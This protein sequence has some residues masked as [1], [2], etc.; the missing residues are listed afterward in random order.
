MI[1]LINYRSTIEEINTTTTSILNTLAACDFSEDQ[2]LVQTIKDIS[3]LNQK[4]TETLKEEIVRSTLAPL[5]AVRDQSAR[6]IF[7]E[8]KAKLLWP[9][10]EIVAAA[11]AVQKILDNYGMEML[12]LSYSAESSNINALLDDLKKQNLVPALKKLHGFDTLIVQLEKD[13]KVFEFAFQEYIA[14][15]AEQSKMLSAGK[16]GEMVKNQINK[17]LSKY[18][19]VMSNV[20]PGIYADCYS[21]I[22]TIIKDNNAK[23]KAR[24]SKLKEKEEV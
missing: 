10:K 18:L 13:Q 21:K 5:D 16:L 24:L 9:D 14:R 7:L 12:N 3:S 2:Y 11:K 23:V 22:E 17:E 4:M 20:K 6:V 19:D 8:I 1:T 15:K